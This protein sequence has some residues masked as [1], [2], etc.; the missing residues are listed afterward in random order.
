MAAL[1]REYLRR[2]GGWEPWGLGLPLPELLRAS[3]EAL[4]LVPSG[5]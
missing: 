3:E 2:A 5:Q 4:V 1:Q